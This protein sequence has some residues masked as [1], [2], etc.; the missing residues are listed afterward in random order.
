M[1]HWVLLA[2][3][4]VLASF[5]LV[6][7]FVGCGEPFESGP[8]SEPPGTDGPPDETPPETKYSNA[9]TETP[10]LVGYWRLGE[11]PGAA[12]AVDLVGGNDGTYNG[13]VTLKVPG[14]V[15]N[16]TDTAAQFDGSTGYVNVPFAPSLNPA[17]FTVEAIVS[18][19]G[20]DA[21][22]R[23]VVSSRDESMG[24]PFGYALYANQDGKWEAWL[25]DG[26]APPKGQPLIGLDVT[27]GTHY[28]AMTYSGSMLN[29]YVD[30]DA[31]VSAQLQYQPNTTGELRIGAG[32]PAAP[33]LFF[34]GVIDEVA[35][36]E[37]ELDPATVQAH[38]KL[39]TGMSP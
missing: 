17:A 1:T 10:G 24:A 38:F 7:A 39:A 3:P 30:A 8:G 20:S 11:D 2:A 16:D 13:G 37:T 25:G 23:A 36:Y 15:A 34:N 32:G 6:L 27:P 33:D 18:V 5:V 14:L 22:Y 29:L 19:I 12:K 35:L 31:P 26:S 21:V 9:V 4:L 28:L